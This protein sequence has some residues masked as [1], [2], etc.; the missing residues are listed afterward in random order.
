MK[1]GM[2]N[3][4]HVQVQVIEL[5]A[6]RVGSRNVDWSGH[7]IWVLLRLF[8]HH[9]GD[10]EWVAIRQ[11]AVKR[12]D[13]HWDG[14]VWS[15]GIGGW[16]GEWV[17][18]WTDKEGEGWR[19]RCARSARNSVGGANMKIMDGT[20]MPFR[21]LVLGLVCL[22]WN[23]LKWLGSGGRDIPLPEYSTSQLR[24]VWPGLGR[25]KCNPWFVW[26]RI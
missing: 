2:Y 10:G 14:V 6:I 9:V 15:A 24:I 21:R 25:N 23:E 1:T 22:G 17:R 7:A 11:P 8:L 12:G 16:L 3:A 13:A 20:I 26:I 19:E 4:V 18:V 5:I